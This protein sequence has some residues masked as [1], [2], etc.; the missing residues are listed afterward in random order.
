MTIFKR[1]YLVQHL[2][3]REKT[4]C[5]REKV[6]TQLSVMSV[7]RIL[8]VANRS[9]G[10]CTNRKLRASSFVSQ[11]NLCT[12]DETKFHPPHPTVMQ[13]LIRIEERVLNVSPPGECQFQPY[14]KISHCAIVKTIEINMA[15][16]IWR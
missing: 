16:Q 8:S 11:M 3:L 1:A 12:S 2:L 4:K 15:T 7:L 14:L 9:I 13:R 5:I 10:R 6:N